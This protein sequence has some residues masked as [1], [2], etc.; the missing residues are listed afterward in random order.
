MCTISLTCKQTETV[1]DR[2]LREL[3]HRMDAYE[4]GELNIVPQAEVYGRIM[5]T[6]CK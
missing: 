6:I 1:A 2:E 5:A 3:E 4:R